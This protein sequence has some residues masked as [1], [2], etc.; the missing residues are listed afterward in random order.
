[1]DMALVPEPVRAGVEQY[2]RFL[3]IVVGAESRMGIP[4]K[5]FAT[6]KSAIVRV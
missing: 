5:V 3:A 1:M 6:Q 2:F 4:K